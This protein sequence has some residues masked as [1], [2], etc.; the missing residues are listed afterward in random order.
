VPVDHRVRIATPAQN[1]TADQVIFRV[2]QVRVTNEQTQIRLSAQV[3]DNPQ[4]QVIIRQIQ[5]IPNLDNSRSIA[6]LV[7]LYTGPQ[8]NN[9]QTYV[10]FGNLLE[11]SSHWRIRLDQFQ[12]YD[13]RPGRQSLD[14]PVGGPWSI[15]FTVPP[16]AGP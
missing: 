7:P 15:E 13:P 1:L 5:L 2:D 16:L 3:A 4:A 6:E 11:T 14:P 10:Y 9:D 8:T 12:V